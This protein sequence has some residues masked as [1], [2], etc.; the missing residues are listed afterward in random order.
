MGDDFADTEAV[1]KRLPQ[2]T[3]EDFLRARRE[4]EQAP[5]P[6]PTTIPTPDFPSFG[7]VRFRCP[8]DCGWHHD[9]NPG[10]EPM[11]PLLLPADFTP[12]DLSAAL[13]SQAEVRHNNFRLRVEQ[14]I[15]DHFAEAHPER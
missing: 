6:P 11:G 10:L 4:A 7:V 12:D 1:M 15:A 14:S 5:P 3:V 9:E 8:L 13:S 2:P